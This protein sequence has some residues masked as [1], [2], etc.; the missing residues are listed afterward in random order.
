MCSCLR[1]EI[2]CL[3]KAYPIAFR[4]AHCLSNARIVGLTRVAVLCRAFEAVDSFLLKFWY[5]SRIR[6]SHDQTEVWH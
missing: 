3:V 6:L 2:A 5:C 1:D 4:V